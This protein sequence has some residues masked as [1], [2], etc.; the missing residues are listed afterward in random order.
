MFQPKFAIVNE[1]SWVACGPGV[2]PSVLLEGR[3]DISDSAMR[4]LAF[5]VP[6]PYSAGWSSNAGWEDDKGLQG[7]GLLWDVPR[8]IRRVAISDR[9]SARAQDEV[10]DQPALDSEMSELARSWATVCARLNWPG[11][12]WRPAL[13]NKQ[14]YLIFGYLDGPSEGGIPEIVLDGCGRTWAGMR[15]R[16]ASFNILVSGA[17]CAFSCVEVRALGDGRDRRVRALDGVDEA[18]LSAIY[19]LV[20]TL[21]GGSSERSTVQL[22]SRTMAGMLTPVGADIC[23]FD[24]FRFM[25]TLSPGLE[26]GRARWGIDLPLDRVDAALAR[27]LEGL[28]V[29]VRSRSV[30]RHAGEVCIA[31]RISEAARI[32]GAGRGGAAL[33]R[34]DVFTRL[35]KVMLRGL[36]RR[37]DG[38]NYIHIAHAVTRVY[39]FHDAIYLTLSHAFASLCDVAAVSAMLRIPEGDVLLECPSRDPGAPPDWLEDAPA[40]ADGRIKRLLG[41]ISGS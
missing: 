33:L 11:Q 38:V 13:I 35:G 39:I 17:P 24:H 3:I 28:A 32:L 1:P 27:M 6:M 29:S 7:D 8:F 22:Q 4:L 26:M 23:S 41:D 14:P 34:N 9:S 18:W 40:V 21:P 10:N 36:G 37:P 30:S 16:E 5:R 15:T 2:D 31:M 20:E 12:D 25:D 19:S